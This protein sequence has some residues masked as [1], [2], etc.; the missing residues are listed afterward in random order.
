MTQTIEELL[1]KPYGEICTAINDLAPKVVD[2]RAHYQTLLAQQ[3]ALIAARELICADLRV[4]D[5][6]RIQGRHDG[7]VCPQAQVVGADGGGPQFQLLDKKGQPYGDRISAFM[8][9]GY[10]K[11]EPAASLPIGK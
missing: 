9:D 1:T 8:L 4:G 10:E 7:K 5:K 6:V 3:S 11:I 2:A